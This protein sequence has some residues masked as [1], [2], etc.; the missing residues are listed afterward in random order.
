MELARRLFIYGKINEEPPANYDEENIDQ[1]IYDPKCKYGTPVLGGINNGYT[2]KELKEFWEKLKGYASYLFNKSHSASYAILTLC[3]MF[4]KKYSRAK[5]FAALLSMQN[6][7]EKIDLYSTVAKFYGINIK[8]PDINYSDIDFIEKDGDILYG[9]RSIKGVGET[10]IPEIIKNRPYENLEDAINKVPKKSLN[11]R[12]LTGL[13][14]SGA[15]DFEDTNR[16]S[17]LNKMMNLRKDKTGR[18]LEAYYSKEDCMDF[19]K[20]TLG[21]YIT[22]IPWINTINDGETFSNVEFNLISTSPRKDKKGNQMAFVTLKKDNVEIKGI[23]FSRLYCSNIQAF[24]CNRTNTI[25]INGKKQ[26]EDI[27][28]S[29][30]I[31]FNLKEEIKESSFLMDMFNLM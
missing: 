30:V 9:L 1:P 31:S 26:G 18:Y 5:F 2:E 10:S 8:T 27:I 7:P 17:L 4:L 3:T 25:V 14:K 24:D 16:F 29:K 13:I 11:K 22:Y 21:T 19:E 15:F 6:T 28:I 20:E 12:V 23:V